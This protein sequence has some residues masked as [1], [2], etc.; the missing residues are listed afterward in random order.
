MMK[1]TRTTFGMLAANRRK[2][3]TEN[4]MVQRQRKDGSWGKPMM[5]AKLFLGETDQDVVDRLNKF[6]SAKYRLAE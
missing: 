6:N 2:A 3:R 5:S 4:V 1:V